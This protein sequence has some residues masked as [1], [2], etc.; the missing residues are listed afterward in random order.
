MEGLACITGFLCWAR[1]Y[2]KFWRIFPIYLL[3]I[4][5]CEFAGWYM[6][7]NAIKGSK[8]MYQYFVIPLEFLFM[9]FLYFKNLPKYFSKITVGLS[10][11][12][13]ASFFAEKLLLKNVKW[14]WMSVSYSVGCL[15]LFILAT[16]YFLSIHQSEKIITYKKEIF[17]WVTLGMV[18]FYVG[19]FP[20]YAMSGVLYKANEGLYNTYSWISIILNYIMYSFFITGFL[21]YRQTEK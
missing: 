3:I 18:L 2:P 11:V 9:Y 5:C 12:Y 16:I 1:L 7:N 19:T 13:I 15:V 10:L 14:L 20:Y 6:T 17:F 21:C 4:F 8:L